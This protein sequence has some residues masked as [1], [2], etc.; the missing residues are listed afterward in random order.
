VGRSGYLDSDVGL[1]DVENMDM[2]KQEE[3]AEPFEDVAPPTPP[4]EELEA[5]EVF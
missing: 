4:V 1:L 3:K 2:P 5:L